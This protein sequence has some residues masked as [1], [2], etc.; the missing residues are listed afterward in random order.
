[1]I[2]VKTLD[3]GIKIVTEEIP[4]VQSISIGF[5]VKA[6]ACNEIEK[7]AGVSHFIEHM[8]F[9]GT[10]KRTAKEIAEDADKIAGNINAYTSKENTCYYIKTLSSNAEKA[11]EILL[12]MF[13]NSTYDAREMTREREVIFEEMNM[14]LDT[15]DDLAYEAAIS[16]LFKGTPLAN[17]IIGTKKSLRNVSKAVLVDYIN[18][19]YTKDS[20]V[21][22]VAGNFDK[23]H[24]YRLFEESKLIELPEAKTP[25][26]FDILPHNPAYTVKVK[27]IEQSHILMATRSLALED[28][29]FYALSLL[30]NIMGGS[31]SS[32]LFQNV[33][34]QKGLAY[35][36]YSML[37]SHTEMGAYCIYAGVGHNK[38]KEAI[39]AIKEE[40]Q[41][42]K[43]EGVTEE[44]LSK[45]K[46]QLKAGY[47]YGQE[48]VN[49]RMFSIGKN[50]LLLN[51]IYTAEQ[52]IEE[53]DNV[54]LDD[55]KRV[56]AL[57]HD[58]EKYSCALVTNKRVD[59]KKYIL[60][61]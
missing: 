53:I 27:D 43:E 48:N 26:K 22:A 38:I 54:T 51:K 19:Q 45:A 50:M 3:C 55:V 6:G 5:F 9:K 42:L 13:L 47:I 30:N 21:I 39:V 16:S 40:L 14:A 57:I 28:D 58:I 23:E 52:V 32:R 59:L 46:E 49:H 34:E 56:S 4:H 17:S 36:V 35:S 12:D 2:E 37:S 25:L 44:E 24:I 29:D 33:R 31:M 41:K 15:P 18:K 8:M 7:Y 20:I 61:K 60:G 10:G 11:I 1:M